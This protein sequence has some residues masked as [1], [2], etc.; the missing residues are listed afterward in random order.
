L[1]MIADSLDFTDLVDDY[2]GDDEGFWR[3]QSFLLERP[4]AGDVIAGTGSLR[5]LRWADPRWAKGKR[6]GLRVIYLFL[7]ELERVLLID[8][9][10]KDEQDD[11]SPARSQRDEDSD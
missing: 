6:G 8:V 2:F 5:K 9:Y 11:I 4:T 3:F 10:G 7:P 1:L